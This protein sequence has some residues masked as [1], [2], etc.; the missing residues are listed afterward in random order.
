MNKVEATI[1]QIAMDYSGL[2]VSLVRKHADQFSADFAVW[3]TDNPHIW[4]AFE[5][6]ANLMWAKG[7]RHYSAYTIVE[8]IRH[9]TALAE[10]SGEWKINNN[11]RPDLA[12]L[13]LLAYPAREGFFDLRVVT[14]RR[15]KGEAK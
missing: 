6:N 13:Y 12:R 8:Y 1:N 11:R 7:R 2:F 10:T 9:E 15:G 14:T 3:L 5:R 4:E